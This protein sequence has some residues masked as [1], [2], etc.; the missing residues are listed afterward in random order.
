M[1][2][3]VRAHHEK[4]GGSGYPDG[5][6]G[7]QIP[8]GSRILSAVDCLDAL[9]SDRQYRRALPLDQAIKVVQ[10][11]VNKA[12]DARVVEVLARRYVEL[13]RMA[14]Q[15]CGGIE[16][17][18]LSVDLKIERGGAPAAGF[19][20]VAS[21][22]GSNRDLVNFHNSLAGGERQM[23]LLEELSI[24][25][26][27]SVDRAQVFSVTQGI[28]RE[29]I[30]YDAM[31]FYVVQDERLLPEYLEGKGSGL[32]A[33]L[34]IPVGM[35]L[36]GWVA[37]NRKTIINGNPAVEPGYLDDPA[38]FITLQSALAAPIEPASGGLLGVL[39]LYHRD[40]DAFT[41]ENLKALLSA[42]TKLA[43]ALELVPVKA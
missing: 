1:A 15:G 31:V 25:L 16:K 35:G 41:N 14:K 42:G 2:P 10:A 34:R 33:S 4:W 38:T 7:E 20:T 27:K 11:D 43:R 30:A 22:N 39:S 28:L 21:T 17:A 23:K 36:S 3:I 29:L 13:E 12:F 19:E 8:I 9:A 37:E 32:F 26:E 6:A 18:K 5:L 24:E 40:R